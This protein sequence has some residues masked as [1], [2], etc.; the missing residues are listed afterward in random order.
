MKKVYPHTTIDS[1]SNGFISL[2]INKICN[3]CTNIK[4]ISKNPPRARIK[5]RGISQ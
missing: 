3:H 2:P 4:N 1:T 5:T